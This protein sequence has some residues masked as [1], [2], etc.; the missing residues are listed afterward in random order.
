MI[1]Q[2][3]L[4]LSEIEQPQVV[5]GRQLAAGHETARRLVASRPCHAEQLLD[6]VHRRLPA[7]V[8]RLEPCRGGTPPRPQGGGAEGP[9]A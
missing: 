7:D 8:Q 1:G 5:G 4:H 3:G 9:K 2:R 6:E